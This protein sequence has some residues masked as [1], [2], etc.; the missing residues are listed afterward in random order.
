[1]TEIRQLL[2]LM[3]PWT[4]W[5]LLGVLI[6]L[7]TSLANITLMS[8]SGWFISAMALAGLA[9]VSMNYFTPAAVI[10]AMAIIRTVGRYTERVITHEATLKL[11]AHLRRWFYDRLEPIAPAGLA[12]LRSGDVFSRIGADIS[13]LENFYLR[14]L[15]PVAVALLAVPIFLLFAAWHSPALAVALAVLY[16]AAGIALPLLIRRLGRRDS[17]ARILEA[18]HLRETLVEGQQALREM[19]VY[20]RAADYQD[21]VDVRSARL[22]ASQRKLAR[23]QAMSQSAITLA[24][25]LAILATLITIIPLVE[26]DTFSGPTLPMLLLFAMA[27]FE[28]ILPLPL[29]M[30]SIMET[31]VAAHRLF[32]LAN[33]T[34][35]VP[36]SQ[37][38]QSADQPSHDA[39]AC[40]ALIVEQASLTYP[41]RDTPAFANLSLT[42]K[43]GERV[44]LLGPSGSGKSSLINALVGFWPLTGG[45]I[46]IDGTPHTT[47][48]P[49]ALRGLFAVAPQKPH[50]FNS[51]LRGNLLLANLEADQA[52]LDHVLELVDLKAFVDSLEKGLDTFIGEAGDTLSGGQIRRM[53]LARALLSP[54]PILIL[55][56]P[57]EGLDPHME[58]AILKRILEDVPQRSVLLITHSRVGLDAMDHICDLTRKEP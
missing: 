34:P 29:A 19:I 20:G 33:Q 58:E 17:E 1:M 11:V 57:G 39:T 36:E 15:V 18:A 46:L 21:A 27:S 14:V 44:A 8:I 10:R 47:F 26:A 4:G 12:H 25:N 9:G 32:S 50:L 35:V 41:D 23:L 5:I 28:V 48:A 54:A 22:T 53:A 37:I 13:I 3:R 38:S 42:L 43:P 49:D 31:K 56:E 30:Q 7:I 51:T 16:V 2:G 45:R 6:S 55:D 52:A 24:S 40:P